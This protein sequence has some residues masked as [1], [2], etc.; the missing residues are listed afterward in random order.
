MRTPYELEL[1]ARIEAGP[2]RYGFRTADGVVSKEAFRPA[3]L[4]LLGVVVPDRDDVLVVDANYGVV[5][6]VLAHVAA[7][8]RTVLAE[9]SARAARLCEGNL[10]RNRA[11]GEVAR[12]GD[13][14]D[15]DGRF[16]VAA[17]APR[18]YDPVPVVTERVGQALAT[19]EAD[20]VLYL[21][22]ANNEGAKRYRDALGGLA[23]DV[24]R[25]H[26][27][28]DVRVYR[29][30]RPTEVGV[31]AVEDR[32]ITAAVRG[33]ERSF[34]TRPGLFSAGH[35]DGG[36][37]LLLEELPVADGDRVLDLACGYGP[38]GVFAATFADCT[39]TMTDDDTIAARYARRNAEGNGVDPDAVL[40]AD[41]VAGVRGRGFD[42]VAS[43]PPTHAGDGVVDE[44]FRGARD[45][46]DADGRFALVYNDVLAYEDRLADLFQEV[47]VVRAEDDFHVTV[48]RRPR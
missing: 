19:L 7:D 3:A 31:P 42:L 32:E 48:C 11:D 26:E 24:E 37:R 34:V 33:V 17:Y 9:T 10:A 38:V 15:V 36:T 14:R 8:G 27:Q 29:A 41:G 5:G 2:D 12:C 13:L 28:G 20:G 35:L 39:V 40:A 4:A 43:N 30:G 47:E 1:A 46:L 16:D 6:T 25:V 22:A 45:V 23:G 21:A 18:S 44:L